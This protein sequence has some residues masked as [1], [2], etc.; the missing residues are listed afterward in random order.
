MA[1]KA[2]DSGTAESG[3][4]WRSEKLGG[5]G[6]KRVSSLRVTLVDDEPTYRFG[7]RQY[8]INECQEKIVATEAATMKD[9]R[10]MVGRNAADVVI[11]SWRLVTGEDLSW[12]ATL[13]SRVRD[14]ISIVAVCSGTKLSVIM[15]AFDA[16]AS[17]IVLRTDE[18]PE[19]ARAI[20]SVASGNTYVCPAAGSIILARFSQIL[21]EASIDGARSI[22]VLSP[23]EAEVFRLIAS[24]HTAK[25][26]AR[27][28]LLSVRTVE[29]H[30][31]NIM[32]KLNVHSTVGLVR[33]SNS[34]D[35][36]NDDL[37]APSRQ[38]EY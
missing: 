26:V 38:A 31:N 27:L 25:E 4:N 34:L 35:L 16:G 8:L 10:S 36:R 22:D 29:N 6:Q 20:R 12:L 9:F 7:L 30:R 21:G 33:L 18:P 37:G 5:R 13:P 32:K 15:S 23:R 11:L 1:R 3:A 17:G 24:G 14:S 2:T 28:L 19:V